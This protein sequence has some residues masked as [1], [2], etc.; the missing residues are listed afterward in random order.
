MIKNDTPEELQVI[1]REIEATITNPAFDDARRM[2]AVK[3]MALALS[4]TADKH[5][6]SM[7][8]VWEINKEVDADPNTPVSEPKFMNRK[9]RIFWDA[10][11]EW[12]LLNTK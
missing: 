7:R 11:A 5:Q 1:L 9:E 6:L 12:D 3:Q 10:V 2:E 4:L 8:E